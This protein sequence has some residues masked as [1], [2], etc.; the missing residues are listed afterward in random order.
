MDKTSIA[1]EAEIAELKHQL[2]DRKTSDAFDKAAG[3]VRKMYD[4]FINAGFTEEQAWEILTIQLKGAAQP[5]R[6]IS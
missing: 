1:L 5:N 4:A 6:S 3:D 2:A